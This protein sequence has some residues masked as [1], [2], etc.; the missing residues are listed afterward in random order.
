MIKGYFFNA[1]KI[2]GEYDRKYSSEDISNW[3]KSIVSNGV[4]AN[5]STNLKVI[6]KE[7]LN[8]AVQAGEGWIN[9]HKMVNTTE[10]ALSIEAANMS[11]PRIDRV[12]F[13]LDYT[14]REMRIYVKKGT[15]ANNPVAPILAKT[16]TLIELALADILLPANTTI[17]ETGMIT[18]QRLNTQL[19]G[20]VHGLIDQVDTT[21]IFEQYQEGFNEWFQNVKDTLTSTSLFREYKKVVYSNIANQK[22]FNIPIEDLHYNSA[23]DILHVYVNGIRLVEGV[24]YS[25]NEKQ[26]FFV[27]PFPVIN[28]PLEITN[29]KSVDYAGVESEIATIESIESKVNKMNYYRY[30]TTGTNDNQN[31]I[32]I[33]SRFYNGIGEFTGVSTDSQLKLSVYGDINITDD[34]API[35]NGNLSSYFTINV[36]STTRKTVYLDFSNCAIYVNLTTAKN[37]D[38]IIEI[39]GKGNVTLINPKIYSVT[40]NNAI[41][42]II[43]DGDIKGGNIYHVNDGA[44]TTKGIKCTS[45]ELTQII[46]S[47]KVEMI[48]NSTNSASNSLIAF[49]GRDVYTDTVMDLRFVNCKADIKTMANTYYQAFGFK[50][51]ANYDGCSAYIYNRGTGEYANTEGF[52]SESKIS[53]TNCQAYVTGS[54]QTRGFNANGMFVNCKSH[55][56]SNSTNQNPCFAFYINGGA[57]GCEGV[58]RN[59][60]NGSAY[61]FYIKDN[62][63]TLRLNNCTGY[64]YCNSAYATAEDVHAYG[65]SANSAVTTQTL[66]CIG[67]QFSKGSRANFTQKGS[68][69]LP[70]T[71]S[72]ANASLIGNILYTDIIKHSGSNVH[73]SGNIV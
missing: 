9:G 12:V 18:D 69:F 45:S 1:K 32:D 15:P 47:V 34:T 2:D 13:A 24:H 4:L 29:W 49:E 8:I 11:L 54:R 40:N 31:I 25:K 71:T 63:A 43:T 14:T 7:R 22:T 42:M 50:G 67:C 64:G 6:P 35:V 38:S 28:T 62:T 33:I 46:D 58:G 59:A 48:G 65:V 3:L 57:D 68:I 17:I 61:G 20:V 16:D 27:N 39:V 10:Y 66:I 73:E 23:L 44:N 41:S 21:G 55:A 51:V 26:I 36:Q 37:I 19:C 60:G 53:C 56:A 5:P 52:S 72:G 30:D 70:G